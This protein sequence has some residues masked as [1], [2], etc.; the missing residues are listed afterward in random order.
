[1]IDGSEKCK[2]LLAFELLNLH[3]F[4]KFSNTLLRH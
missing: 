1:M 4:E 3:V 2:C